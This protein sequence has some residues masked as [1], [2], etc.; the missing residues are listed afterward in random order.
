MKQRSHVLF[1]CVVVLGFLAVPAFADVIYLNNGDII[2]GELVSAN[3]TQITI[4][5]PYGKLEIPKAD[6]KSIGT[7]EAAPATEEAE[8]AEDVAPSP[9]D[10]AASEVSLNIRGRSF[11]YAF[12]SPADTSIRLRLSL[13]ND[14]AC[15]FMDDKPDTVDGGTLYNSFT[16]SP[17]DSR[18]VETAEGFQCAV[19]KA[20][21][22]DVALVVGLAPSAQTGRRTMWMVYEVNEGEKSSPRWVDVITRS[23]AL[24]LAPGKRSVVA[25]EQDATALDY[26]GMFK[27][28]M[29]NLE[30]FQVIVVKAELRD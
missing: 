26:S 7:P 5:T 24:E 13:D 20:D 22:G 18:L 19:E 25:L 11:W 10:G 27:K 23:F 12:E 30:Q 17:T 29:K 15:T 9:G 28:T 4:Q 21:N 6:V 2:H 1:V 3:N 14:R 8:A 16:F